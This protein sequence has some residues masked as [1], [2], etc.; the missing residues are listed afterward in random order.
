LVP[1]LALFGLALVPF[2]LLMLTSFVKISVVLSI[3][4]SAFGSSHVPPTMVLLGLAFVL[5]AYVMSPVAEAAYRDAKPVLDRAPA[6]DVVSAR[7]A[8][9]L[10]MAAD[11]GKEPV[12]AFLLRH[13][14]N[15]ERA[16][17]FDLARRMRPA[18]EQATVA[19]NDFLVLVPAFVVSELKSAFQI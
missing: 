16:T 12:R 5:T 13:A 9:T 18:A 11:R 19:N 3:L 17:F 8:A 1:L 2:V 15:A 4:R 6:A 10:S 14:G 7:T